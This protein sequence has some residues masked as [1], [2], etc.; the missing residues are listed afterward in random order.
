M[1][2]E[3]FLSLYKFWIFLFSEIFWI[4]NY[5]FWGF[6]SWVW[7]FWNTS[8]HNKPIFHIISQTR[9]Q[10]CC[11]VQCA[12]YRLRF[13]ADFPRFNNHLVKCS[14]THDSNSSWIVDRLQSTISWGP[15]NTRNVYV[16]IVET[17]YLDFF[18]RST[19]DFPKNKI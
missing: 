18:D 10:W 6:W 7:H 4:F 3:K 5:G 8:V 16:Y 15:N 2:R 13:F 19:L 12:L 17:Q 9:L 14:T 11:I 1:I